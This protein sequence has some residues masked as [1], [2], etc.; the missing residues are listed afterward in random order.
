MK[1]VATF[2]VRRL[3]VNSITQLKS[4]I[5]KRGYICPVPPCWV[6]FVE[7]LKQANTPTEPPQAYILGY[8]FDTSSEQKTAQLLKQLEWASENNC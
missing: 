5:Y 2:L 8:W 3:L 6:R 4:E 7:L 1:N